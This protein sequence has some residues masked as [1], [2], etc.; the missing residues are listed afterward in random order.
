MKSDEAKIISEAAKKKAWKD[1]E[2]KYPFAD[3]SKFEAE[4]D[5]IEKHVTADIKFKASPDL[6]QSVSGSDR[7]YWSDD[8]KKALGIG[9]FPVELSLSILILQ[10][11]FRRFN[12]SNGPANK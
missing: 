2:T 11:L 12:L 1:F 7:K 6:L 9:G 10:I 4:V 5:F 8:M 3:L